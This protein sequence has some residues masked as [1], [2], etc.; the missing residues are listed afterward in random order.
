MDDEVDPGLY[1]IPSV[2]M[3][4]TVDLYEDLRA[5]LERIYPEGDWDD[6]P[7]VLQFASW[8]GG[9]REAATPT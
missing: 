4:Q 1:F 9:D 5:A 2:I 8:I 6:L 7:S 3:E